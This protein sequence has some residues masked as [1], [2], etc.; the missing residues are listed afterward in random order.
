MNRLL[1]WIKNVLVRFRKAGFGIF[2]IKNLFLLPDFFTDNDLNIFSKMKVAFTFLITLFYFMSSIDLMP[3]FLFG[4]LGFIDDLLILIWAIG[5]INEE[6]LNYKML[7]QN[8]PKS[9]IIEDV[10]WEIKDDM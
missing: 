3:E 1:D 10:N 7:L 9:K 8:S 6:L 2:F 4:S 5:L